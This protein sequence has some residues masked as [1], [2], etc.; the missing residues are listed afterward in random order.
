MTEKP[1]RRR[2]II[3]DADIFSAFDRWASPGLKSQKLFAANVREALSQLYPGKEVLQYDA[4][5][6]LKS[7]AKRGLLK[8]VRSAPNA[9][10]WMII[11]GQHGKN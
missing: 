8:E 3:T 9:T 1:R 5:Q 4:L 2:V 10:A 11:G 6:K 7:M